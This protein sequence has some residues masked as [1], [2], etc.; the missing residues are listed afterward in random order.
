[1]GR[2]ADAPI[3]GQ[4]IHL[5]GRALRSQE[6]MAEDLGQEDVI[7]LVRGFKAVAAD[8]AVG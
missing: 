6:F 8:G 5:F 2:W 3:D 4:L 7:G 1:M